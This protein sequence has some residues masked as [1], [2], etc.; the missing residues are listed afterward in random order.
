MG[1]GGA[2]SQA[3]SSNKGGAGG[4]GGSAL[5]GASGIA[6]AAGSGGAASYSPC[7]PVG[8][9]CKVLPFGDSITDGF[10]VPGGYRMELFRSARTASKSLTFVGSLVNGPTQVDDVTF[11][12][13]HE[14]HSGFTI[15]NEPQ[16]SR[17][18]I[19]PLANGVMTSYEP[20]IVLL[21]IG[22][23]DVNVNAGLGTANLRLGALMD[24][25]L[26]ADAN[27][28]LAV[29]QITPTRVDNL[30]TRVQNYNA[31]IPALVAT[32]ANAGKHVILVDMYG[33]FT[34]DGNYKTTLLADD[35]HPSTAG[36]QRIAQTW[37]QALSGYLR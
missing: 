27:V 33:A 14:G 26:A 10:N 4:A 30:N 3:G 8:Q 17:S 11:P 13:N 12:R 15:D 24:R 35:L 19:S 32:R 2:T 21:M 6:G 36:Y 37:Y 5:G 28:L 7:P 22:T 34:R 31:T 16:A 20:H 29:A 1:G 9:P 25:I 23:N 18:G